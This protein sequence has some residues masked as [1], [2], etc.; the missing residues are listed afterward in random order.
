MPIFGANVF[1]ENSTVGATTDPDGKFR[2]Q[3]IRGSNQN[4]VVSHLAYYSQTVS[5]R[6][7]TR[8]DF[9]MIPKV[10]QLSD[11]EIEQ[12]KD[13]RTMRASQNQDK[14]YIST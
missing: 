12:D 2:I 4:V 13:R 8:I 10:T 7:R 14:H 9:K 6:G 11:F 5:L 3:N 1:I